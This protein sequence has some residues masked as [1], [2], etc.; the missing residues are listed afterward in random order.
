M[1]ARYDVDSIMEYLRNQPDIN[2]DDYDG[3]YELLR[4]T[5]RSY[6]AIKDDPMLDYHDL[7]ALYFMVVGTWKH[8]IDRK[9]AVIQESHLPEAEKSR[10]LSVINRIWERV[11]AREYIHQR[12][13]DPPRMGMF[14]TGF[15]TFKG[16]AP[17]QCASAFVRMCAE[18]FPLTD[19]DDIF[20]RVEQVLTHGF[21][22][23]QAASV[24]VILHCMKPDVFPILNGNM[25]TDNIF[26]TLGLHLNKRGEALTY[27]A[28]CRIIRAFRDQNF[29]FR[30]YR[31]FDTAQHAMT[32]FAISEKSAQN[33]AK[34]AHQEEIASIATMA[35][36]SQL[37]SEPKQITER[38]LS[39]LTGS[40]DTIWFESHATQTSVYYRNAIFARIFYRAD[41]IRVE[42]Y[43]NPAVHALYDELQAESIAYQKPSAD[44]YSTPGKYSFFVRM[45]DVEAAL[46]A[47]MI[48]VQDGNLIPDTVQTRKSR[49]HVLPAA[50]TES[51][52]PRTME[53]L[54]RL[55]YD[56]L[57]ELF[58]QWCKDSGLAPSA[59]M[60]FVSDCFYLWRKEDPAQFWLAVESDD[61]VM[62]SILYQSLRKN[63]SGDA[64]KN[65]PGYA[66][67][68]R[69]FRAFVSS[70]LKGETIAASNRN[71]NAVPP[72]TIQPPVDLAVTGR[73][74]QPAYPDRPQ[75]PVRTQ[76]INSR[77]E[78]KLDSIIG[79]IATMYSKKSSTTGAAAPA[80]VETN[81][82]F[83]IE[84]TQ[85][86]TPVLM[87]KKRPAITGLIFTLKLCAV[88]VESSAERYQV[89]FANKN[90]E[91][92]SEPQEIDAV[93]GEEYTCRFELKSSASE[94]KAVYLAVRSVNALPDEVRQLIE[95]PVKIAFAADF[96]L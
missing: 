88:G 4:E 49:P 12:D 81:P 59:Y 79:D 27:I 62:N 35:N 61:T 17:D 82:R 16:K 45:Q 94:E 89:F 22:G 24:S 38:I 47:I 31:V 6:T 8:G 60:T 64:D 42:M 29:T 55:G 74:A 10:L 44:P 50:E 19:E 84:A 92:M 56:G 65:A 95:I 86:N 15:M 26:D 72:A 25:G 1:K 9:K 37:G 32:Q 83:R 14:G 70:W 33:T 52:T 40:D 91:P 20:R 18:I 75:A 77:L 11:C 57:R 68:I 87:F 69:R 96:G 23:M 80:P 78:K 46:M 28:N 30:N 93:A 7:N 76:E 21:R 13:S 48:S 58:I 51:K 90:A 2:P 3:S 63:S 39:E 73:T 54:K 66:R 67:A 34:K 85:G 43:D 36:D 41:A 53:D 5:V 71:A